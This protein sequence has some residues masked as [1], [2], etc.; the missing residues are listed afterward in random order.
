MTDEALKHF[1]TLGFLVCRQFLSPDETKRLS[2]TFDGAMKRARQD[3]P[4]PERGEPRQQVN[5]MIDPFLPFFEFDPDAF[6][7]LLVDPRFVDVFGN[8]LGDDFIL[9]GTEGILHTGDTPWHH[10]NVAPE[11]YMTMRAHIYLDY[12][13]P[14][15][16]C[17]SVIPGS[18]LRE[19]RQALEKDLHGEPYNA[20]T[21]MGVHPENVPGRYSIV[22]APGDVSFMNHKL[23][24][25]ALGSKGYRRC[26]HINATKSAN[27]H[28]EPELLHEL[29]NHIACQYAEVRI[30]A[31]AALRRIGTPEA[32]RVLEED[33]PSATD[34]RKRDSDRRIRSLLGLPESIEH[35]DAD[36][37]ERR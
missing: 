33:E 10:D 35:V 32:L 17:L 15:D 16:G 13:G 14:D 29:K 7:P 37:K 23:F 25:A 12:L 26:I 21:G 31:A 11:G 22:N 1:R 4:L 36:D 18:H 20:I 6:N 30:T 19:F 9:P 2:D 27:T 28:S 3:A 5:F 8:L 24:H 34:S